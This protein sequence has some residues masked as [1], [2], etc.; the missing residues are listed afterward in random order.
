MTR[1]FVRHLLYGTVY[2]IEMTTSGEI[3]AAAVVTDATACKHR[4]HEY[5]L[6]LDAAEQIRDH[7]GDFE[8]FDPVCN[9]ARHL[10]SDIGIATRVADRAEQEYEQAARVAKAAKEN[11][12]RARAAVLQLTRDATNPRPLPLFDQPEAR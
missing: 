4:L 9:D 8:P 3:G 2:A 10:L 5:Q 1:S 6:S 12:E 7:R 11:S